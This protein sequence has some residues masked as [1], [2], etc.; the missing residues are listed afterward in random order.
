M[1]SENQIKCIRCGSSDA[2]ILAG[3]VDPDKYGYRCRNCPASWSA[4]ESKQL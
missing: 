3:H 4:V 1:R 2:Y